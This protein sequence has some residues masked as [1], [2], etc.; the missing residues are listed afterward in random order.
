MSPH[1]LPIAPRPYSGETFDSWVQRL[2]AANFQALTHTFLALGLTERA[3]HRE[4][5]DNYGLHLTDGQFRAI[6]SA[7]GLGRD[8]IAPLLL[9]TWIGGPAIG[10][11]RQG[12][13]IGDDARRFGHQNWLYLGGSHYCP[14]CLGENMGAWRLEWRLPWCFAC[15]RHGRI[16][17]AVCPGCGQRAATGRTDGRLAPAFPGSVPR[18]GHCHNPQGGSRGKGRRDPCHYPLD[19]APVGPKLPGSLLAIQ[20]EVLDAVSTQGREWW[21]DLRVLSIYPLVAGRS[22]TLSL[23]S[24]DVSLPD[25]V[26]AA[27]KS[28]TQVRDAA[29]AERR[30][31]VAAQ[32]LDHRRGS[33]SSTAKTPPTDPLLMAGAT[34]I[35]LSALRS[36]HHLQSLITEGQHD[37][38]GAVPTARVKQ[39]GATADLNNR[40]LMAHLGERRH[41]HATGL[42]SR[43]VSTSTRAITWDPDSLPPYLWDD[44]YDEHLAQHLDPLPVLRRTGRRFASVALYKSAAGCNWTQAAEHFADGVLSSP[45]IA[46]NVLDHATRHGGETARIRMLDAIDAVSVD[47]DSDDRVAEYAGIRTAAGLLLSVPVPEDVYRHCLVEDRPRTVTATQLIWAAAWTWADITLDDRARAPI[48]GTGPTANDLESYGRWF[49]NAHQD[50]LAGLRQ[51]AL[52]HLHEARLQE[53]SLRGK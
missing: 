7:V 22:E 44:L 35:A 48:W 16:L 6:D 13:P 50:T 3:H 41:L 27:W 36:D 52:A 10:V 49:K 21:N 37:P 25:E 30:R 33:K 28:A 51:W 40:A 39:L 46:L 8:V 26:T 38:T 43:Y 18:P 1:S 11:D 15:V 31:T 24:G 34:V 32:G 17:L 45:K 42:A 4:L 23:L 29:L 5:P 53:R 2:S 14:E 12:A 19:R 47:L 9:A 20:R